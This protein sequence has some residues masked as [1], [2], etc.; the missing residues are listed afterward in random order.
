MKKKKK[1]LK[2]AYSLAEN[3]YRVILNDAGLTQCNRLAEDPLMP[4]TTYKG[5]LEIFVN[6]IIFV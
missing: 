2:F 3:L 5:I 1:V 6:K 4:L